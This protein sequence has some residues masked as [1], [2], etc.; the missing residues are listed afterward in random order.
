M[1]SDR[2]VEY[3]EPVT[4]LGGGAADPDQLRFALAR[5]PHLV[6]A[7]GGAN[8]ALAEGL[9]PDLLIGDFDSVA[10]ETLAAIPADRHVRLSEQET[11]DFEKCLTRTRAP[12]ILGV[13]FW[14]ARADHGLAVLSAMVRHPH[15]PCLIMG[16][17]DVIFAAPPAIDLPV[18]DGARLS[19]FPMLPVAGESSGLRWPIGGIR[20]DPG[21]MIGTS[22][23]AT[24]PV[25][26]RFHN[27]GMLVILPVGAAD[28]AIRALLSAPGWPAPIWP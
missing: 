26:L 16:E 22:N 11:T 24:G 23:Q 9:M 18:A 8:M 25:R 4:L 20:F 5:A 13:G 14:G 1:M 21:G 2:I 12:L 3:H 15:R 28:L 6:A 7:D 27:P 10:A 17:A 19:L